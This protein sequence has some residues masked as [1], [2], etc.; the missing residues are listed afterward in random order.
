M[1]IIIKIIRIYIFVVIFTYTI[2][3]TIYINIISRKMS[4]NCRFKPTCSKYAY[5]S[6]IRQYHVTFI[7]I[8]IANCI[9]ICKNMHEKYNGVYKHVNC[10]IYNM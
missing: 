6:N 3:F 5:I 2:L 10:L 9:S 8:R 4:K 1:F 7:I